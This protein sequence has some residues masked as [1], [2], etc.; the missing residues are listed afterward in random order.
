LQL[1]IDARPD[2]HDIDGLDRPDS[3]QQQR[4]ILPRDS[5]DRDRYRWRLG[6]GFRFGG[7][8]PAIEGIPDAGGCGDGDD[9]AG[10]QAFPP[11]ECSDLSLGHEKAFPQKARDALLWNSDM[12]GRINP[13]IGKIIKVR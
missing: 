1:A 10:Q 2:R 9:K 3:F 13:S 11:R 5:R 8:A 4:N 12:E 6:T 7:D